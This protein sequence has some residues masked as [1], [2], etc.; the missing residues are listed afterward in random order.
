MRPQRRVDSFL[1][2]QPDRFARGPPDRLRRQRPGLLRPQEKLLPEI[3]HL[4][5]RMFFI[6]DDEVGERAHRRRIAQAGQVGVDVR[7]EFV[8]EHGQRR[9]VRRRPSRDKSRAVGMFAGSITSAPRSRIER[10]RFGRNGVGRRAVAP[11]DVRGTPIRAPRKPSGSR[12]ACSRGWAP[13]VA[14]SA[15]SGPA[16]A[17]SRM[18]ASATVRVI[19]RP[20]PGCERSGSPRPGS[21]SRRSV[22]AD[23]GVAGGR[24]VEPSVS[25]PTAPAA[26]PAAMA[27]PEPALDPHGVA[28][29][30]YGL[31]V[32]RRGRSRRN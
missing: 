32:G 23:D 5:R 24:A 8:E 1:A 7:F 27:A 14:G 2:G 6:E 16:S 9:V 12:C 17:P 21:S 25:V 4:F 20:Y 13:R 31:R 18:A 29:S 26:S 30:A 11:I 22:D 28:S 3:G 15:G 19:G 10:D